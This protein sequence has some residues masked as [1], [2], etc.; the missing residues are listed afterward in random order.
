MFFCV[1]TGVNAQDAGNDPTNFV[2]NIIP[3][4]PTAYALG[5]YVN[6][7]VGLF[8][9]SQ[10]INIPLYSY[11][12]ANLEVPI[13]MFYSS[14]G[15]KVDEISSNI[16][17]GWNLN[18]GGVITRVVRDK[19]DEDRGEYPI[20]ISVTEEMGRYSPQSLEFYQY[21]GENDV[22]T[23]SDIFS[24]NFGKY[25]GKFVF[26]NNG[27]IVLMPAQEFQIETTNSSE[28]FD[29]VITASDGVKYYFSDKEI[30][31]QRVLGS[32]HSI[33]NITVSS[34]YLSKIV[35]PKGDE[36]QF[37][38]NNT[39]SSYVASK[40]QTF[41]MLSP[42]IQ[43]DEAGNLEYPT[44]ALSAVCDHSIS[45]NG[46]AIKSIKSNNLFYG[47]VTF[48]YLTSSSADVTSGN[49]KISQI[50]IKD[51][52]AAEI[53][54]I[55][56]T[57][58]TTTNKRVFLDKI[59]FKDPNQNYQFEYDDRNNLPQ[60]LSYSQDHWGYY[61]GKNNLN[62]VPK[63]ILLYDLNFANYNGADKEPDVNYVKKGLLTKIVYPT[64]GYTLFDYEPNTY[65]GIK[66]VYP[67]KV[68]KNLGAVTT[69]E[70]HSDI[71]KLTF[72]NTT[73]QD[74]PLVAGVSFYCSD[75][76]LNIG[77]NQ[78]YVSVYDNTA[79]LY[80]SLRRSDNNAV[81][82]DGSMYTI[83]PNTEPAAKNLLFTA[84]L[85][86]EYIV[87]LESDF[88]CT[89][90]TLNLNYY[91][92]A[93]VNQQANLITG[94]VRVSRTADY[95]LNKPEPVIKQ[96]IYA[97][98][99]DLN[100]S[101]GNQGQN[102]YYLDRFRVDRIMD[103][104][105]NGVF[106][107]VTSKTMLNL[108]SSS[109]VSLFDT[110][111]SN[112]YYK[113]VTISYGDNFLNGGEEHEFIIHRD[114]PDGF[115]FGG[116][117]VRSV[118]FSNGGWDNGLLK[119]VDYF[120]K[121]LK[122]IKETINTYEERPEFRKEVRSFNAR[123]NFEKI[124]SG[125]VNYACTQADLTKRT[126]YRT[127]V[128][129][130]KHLH[131]T[132]G[133]FGS[134]WVCIALGHDNRTIYFNHPCYGAVLPKTI[135]N[136]ENIDNLSIVSYKNTGFWH[137]LKSSQE[138]TY[139]I[140]GLNPL[141]STV[142]YNYRGINHI[143]LSSQTT[144]NS[145][146]ETIETKYFYAKDTEIANKPS[147]TQLVEANII[148][149]PLNIITYNGGTKL[150]EQLT[151]YEKSTA[152][153]NLLLP[154]AIYSSKFPNMLPVIL[155]DKNLEKKI[156]FDQYDSKGNITQYT[157]ENGTSVSFIWGYD[158]TLPIAKIENATL[159]QI[160]SALGI[161]TAVLDTY[162]EA[163][164][165][166]LNG[167]R[168]NASLVNSMITTFTHLPLIGISTVTDPKGDVMTYNY[169]SFNRLLTVRDRSNNILSENQYH[170][171]N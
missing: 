54:K 92:S 84:E 35:H 46:K 74:I 12:T 14:N 147:I 62:I 1:L 121:D 140:K 167:L 50:I 126:E 51:G 108:S 158:K 85:N 83:K 115:V 65:P 19:P 86:H 152:T 17:Q 40:S 109:L 164:M 129:D 153:S 122:T 136:L 169:D 117:D 7:P 2:P 137:Y 134:S 31:T 131:M 143:Q 107:V 150:S 168:S 9:G 60:R 20:P 149:T 162:T 139:D 165:A 145:K 112:V 93:P 166:V 151:T 104:P 78:A 97:K 8:T 63:N 66:K 53:D 124:S 154:K 87:T 29:F 22:D 144:T 88:T 170:Y 58:T 103:S 106:G 82:S 36:I 102:P 59:Q 130:H 25:S 10:N 105:I 18:L 90:S 39:T 33:P 125:D 56:F 114:A 91:P 101:S 113:Y 32:G 146:K 55:G 49:N 119:R 23:E 79:K 141:S 34:W 128:A 24:F 76:G 30:T 43:Y 11:K 61:N 37:V 45:L 96:I 5:T 98:R 99:T 15:I 42:R 133:L 156:T 135:S 75:E 73:L 138:I 132:N 120:N 64:K 160:A 52:A 161:T 72:T 38:Y 80:V 48:T 69:E 118:P 47:E 26:D 27:A 16:G 100:T 68:Y 71:K 94:G 95:S 67:P 3:P 155:T 81:I 28:G 89:S 157:L 127:C 159:A 116:Y 77:K 171:K 110:G 4:S 6:N 111:S 148:E 123:K 44:E 21:I 70:T 13:S 163:N 41:R 57:Y 142:T